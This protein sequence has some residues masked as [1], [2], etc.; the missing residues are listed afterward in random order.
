MSIPRLA[1]SANLPELSGHLR[2]LGGL[3]QLRTEPVWLILPHGLNV[4]P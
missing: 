4:R 2:N 3:M 1:K